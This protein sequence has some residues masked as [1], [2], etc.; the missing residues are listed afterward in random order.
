MEID[1]GDEGT[2]QASFQLTLATPSD[3]TVTVDFNTTDDTAVA[4]EDY[5]ST[6]GTVTFPEGATSAQ[7]P[8]TILGDGILEPDREAFFLELSNALGASL[9]D[10]KAIGEIVD[11]ELCQGPNLVLNG[12]GEILSGQSEINAWQV[13]QGTWRL[14]T[15]DPA[16]Y[17]GNRF[18]ATYPAE[19]A[20]LTQDIDVSAYADRIDGGDQWFGVSAS[21]QTSG[22]RTGRLLVEYFDESRTWLL[23]DYDSGE[24]QAPGN[25]AQISE[26]RRLPYDTRWVRVRLLAYG[27][28]ESEDEAFFDAVDLWSERT[29][30]AWLEASEVYEGQ[31][32][33][34][35]LPFTVRLACPYHQDFEATFSTTDGS[36]VAGLDY[37]STTEQVVV[38]SGQTSEEIP[39]TVY[40]DIEDEGHE[41]LYGSIEPE[42]P[43]PVILES[44]ALGIILNDDF[45][46]R[47]AS[48]W[49]SNPESWVADQLTLGN[50]DYNAASL[51]ILLGYGGKDASARLARE[52]TAVSFNLLA[53]SDPAIGAIVADAD[54][55][56]ATY[57]PGSNPKGRSKQEANALKNAL[58]DY[59]NAICQSGL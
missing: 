17:D 47:S 24:Q 38:P 10:A 12:S 32:S 40:G 11:D 48:W 4:D 43:A 9:D 3:G 15:E 49:L 23:D 8:V 22:M 19:V 54:D 58:E 21:L 34:V 50:V 57:P 18:F 36:A 35:D 27:D 6:A 52:L 30:A 44:S 45:C 51:E 13:V 16:P 25:W 55:F 37:Q 20:E 41:G 28:P 5:R 7:V 14:E 33:T 46:P 31:V 56:L 1:E 29:I 59:N 53:G 2:T 42:D 26:T 39:V